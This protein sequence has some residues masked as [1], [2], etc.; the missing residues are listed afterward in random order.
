MDPTSASSQNNQ[1]FGKNNL[2][3]RP[4]RYLP[5]SG[6]PPKNIEGDNYNI[7]VPPSGILDSSKMP[8]NPNGA[9]KPDKNIKVD[10]ALN[11]AP[12]AAAGSV[13]DNAGAGAV[14]KPISRPDQ[15][16]QNNFSF[17][18]AQPAQTQNDHKNPDQYKLSTAE[19]QGPK[20]PFCRMRNAR[21]L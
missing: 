21:T 14:P 5:N 10:L 19:V 16:A 17:A 9:V 1:N 13:K 7:K 4:E 12:A 20:P 8:L 15:P 3:S 18:E 2:N 11:G 6:N